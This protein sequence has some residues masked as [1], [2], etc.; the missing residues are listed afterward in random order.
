MAKTLHSIQHDSPIHIA[1]EGENIVDMESVGTTKMSC[2]DHNSSSLE[3]SVSDNK[4]YTDFK[5]NHSCPMEVDAN[6]ND[7][8][9]CPVN[10]ESNIEED[11]NPLDKF[12]CTEKEI[13]LIET[14][15]NNKFFTRGPDENSR[16]VSL[17]NHTFC[18]E[19][20][21]P[22]LLPTG[23]LGFQA[24]CFVTLSATRYFNQRLLS[25]T[26]KFSSDSDYLVF[27]HSVIQKLN[28]NSY[29]N[30]AMRKDVSINS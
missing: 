3:Y 16:P 9:S 21:H 1:I 5:I 12:R 13:T 14:S 29:F 11:E 27:A 17:G 18:E 23:K 6:I 24:K 10:Q 25:C 19:L 4:D 26:Q 15:Y 7:H 8:T 2:V 28:I 30:I 20:S 22:R